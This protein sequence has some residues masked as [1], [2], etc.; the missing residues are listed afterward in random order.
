ML[1]NFDLF[2]TIFKINVVTFGGGYTIAPIIMDEFVNKRNLI[3]QEEMLDIIALAQSG[4]G[5]LAVSTCLLTGYKINGIKGAFIC[6]LG[7][8]L[9]PLMVITVVYYFYASFQNNLYV[10]AA[11]RGM[12]GIISAILIITSIN[13]GRFALK[14][15]PI[16]SGIVMIGSFII[17]FLT[18]INTAIIIFA[19]ALIGIVLFGQKEVKIP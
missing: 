6:T 5:A 13:L 8:V 4:P 15:H 19:L 14:K 12:S 7:S 11:L 3:S 1:S 10:R 18:S 17:S 9:P 2:Y 16:F